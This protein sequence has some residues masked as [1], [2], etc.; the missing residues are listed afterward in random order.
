MK[1][2]PSDYRK[3]L[4][5]LRKENLSDGG[6]VFAI[7]NVD[8][9]DKSFEA[10]E[11]DWRIRLTLQGQG[12]F[13]FELNGKNLDTVIELLG[14]SFHNWRGKQLGLCLAQFTTKQG[15]EREYIKI[16]PASKIKL[17]KP[18][19]QKSPDEDNG[20]FA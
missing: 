6:N 18:S 1:A 14:D 20:L 10:N 8:E 11:H 19:Q 13:W 4:R 7:T 12:S 3:G 9:I 2:K 5:Y 17:R 16:V 15:E